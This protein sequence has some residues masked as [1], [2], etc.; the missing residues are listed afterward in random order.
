MVKKTC[1]KHEKHEKE[2]EEAEAGG[3]LLK[4]HISVCCVTYNFLQF[5]LTCG[6]VT[7]YKKYHSN[8]IEWS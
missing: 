4:T 3:K 6:N 8:T 1:A 5:L 7:P 2:K